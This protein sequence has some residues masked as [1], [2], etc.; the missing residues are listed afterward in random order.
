MPHRLEL[1]SYA[2][3]ARIKILRHTGSM[4]HRLE[5]NPMPHRLELKSYATQALC[6]TGFMPHRLELESYATQALIK[7]LCHTGLN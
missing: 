3:Q 6:H 2:T 7:I 5:L 4:P 1:K